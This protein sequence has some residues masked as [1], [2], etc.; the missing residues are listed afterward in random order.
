[1][2]FSDYDLIDGEGQ[3]IG[4]VRLDHASFVRHPMLALLNGCINGCTL[5]IPLAILREFGLF[6]T[7]FRYVQD[8]DMWNKI[9]SRY[10]F[11][12]QPESL[13]E[14]RVHPGQG[15]QKPG[16]MI[17]GNELWVRM[18]ESR[19]I[20]ERAALYGSS[21]S[22][23][24]KIGTLLDNTPYKMAAIYTRER[25]KRIVPETL[26]SV[27]L[28][29]VQDAKPAL[30]AAQSVL[31]QTHGRLELLLVEDGS[32]RRA[33]GIDALQ[34]ADPRVRL[35]SEDRAGPASARNR[36]LQRAEGEYIAFLDPTDRF[37]P[38][39]IQRQLTE[40]QERGKL[41]S[42]TS[43]DVIFADRCWTVGRVN[44]GQFSG[45]VYPEI[46][47]YCPIVT[48]TVMLHRW[49]V[50]AG[51]M[52]DADCGCGD[53]IMRW[54]TIAQSHELL[55][56]DEPLSV[57][58]WSNSCAAINLEHG[59]HA[60]ARVL[61]EIASHPVHSRHHAEVRA[62]AESYRELTASIRATAAANEYGG[63]RLNEKMIARAFA[64]PPS[65]DG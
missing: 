31:A 32:T 45:M 14:Y 63:Q 54:I 22:F 10:E 26:V 2:L 5:M 23:F 13:I 42:H 1:M 20:A 39:K 9:L 37:A 19:S 65:C 16:A 38:Q 40:M 24:D 49:L 43:Y 6:D 51:Y 58:Q 3:T 60:T 41:F 64:P 56:I 62:R 33:V 8:Y 57:V 28:P 46:L 21:K 4:A 30:E 17:E 50:D 47:G 7:R 55:G 36:A 53:D 35:I 15:T 59:L 18:A 25:A 12:H 52:S 61:E 29:I 11:F 44:S 27:V 48:S 34:R